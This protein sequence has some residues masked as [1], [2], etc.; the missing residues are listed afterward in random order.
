[1][2][3]LVLAAAFFAGIHV[4]VSG[5]ALRGAIV[6]RIGENA[7][8]GLFSIA[9]LAAIWWMARA[10]AAAPTVALWTPPPGAS[11]ALALVLVALAFALVVIGLATP[12][13]TVVGG[14]AQL[15]KTS[16]EP[17]RGIL[18]ITRHPFLT[19]VALWAIAHLV[20][21]GDAASVVLFGTFLGVAALGPFLIDRKRR[22]ALGAAWDPFARA[23][24]VVPF[25]A[26]AAGRNRLA[27]REIGAGRLAAAA[28]AYAILLASHRALFGVSPLP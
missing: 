26:I 22:A 13:P 25:A 28:A 2:A 24:S 14:E 17:A 16:D 18:R 15:A 11:R 7:F 20:A 9:S 23:T 10:Y 12:S 21:N 27:L 19:G 5:T 1:M 4:F 6:S 8:R 3:S